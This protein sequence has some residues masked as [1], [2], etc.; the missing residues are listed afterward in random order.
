MYGIEEVKVM[1]PDPSFNSPLRWFHRFGGK[2]KVSPTFNTTLS[3]LSVLS[4]ENDSIIL[5]VYQNDYAAH[6]LEPEWLRIP[7]VRY[8]KL[9][10][11]AA[12]G[13]LRTWIEL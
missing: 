12:K 8:F 6:H 3:A 7:T 10:P 5:D 4:V 2:R 1:P 9:G 11:V 13:G